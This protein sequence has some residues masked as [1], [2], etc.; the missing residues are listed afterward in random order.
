VELVTV[1][2]TLNGNNE[3]ESVNIVMSHCG[4]N[5][6]DYVSTRQELSVNDLYEEAAVIL[7]NICRGL[8]VSRT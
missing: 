5:L 3:P 4:V 6:V 1:Y 2:M 7:Y 8:N